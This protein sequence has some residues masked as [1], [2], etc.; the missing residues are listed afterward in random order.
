MPAPTK[1]L[2][3][4]FVFVINQPDG[5][6]LRTNE[7]GTTDFTNMTITLD[8]SYVEQ[9]RQKV[10]IHEVLHA[11][12]F[13]VGVGE[14]DEPLGEEKWVTATASML[15]DTLRRNPDLVAY[16]MEDTSASQ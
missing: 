12:A 14:K 2:V 11:V 15:W 1:V 9:H 6:A 5:H 4:P 7:R 3:G 8:P 16:L 10:L 13:A